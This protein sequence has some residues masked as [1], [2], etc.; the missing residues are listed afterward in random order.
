MSP[1]PH[2]YN[3]VALPE[4]PTSFAWK[5]ISPYQADEEFLAGVNTALPVASDTPYDTPL[6]VALPL[7]SNTPYDTPLVASPHLSP[8]ETL[9]PPLVTAL[10]SVAPISFTLDFDDEDYLHS[11]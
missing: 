4:D 11:S 3:N 8:I 9:P 7:A 5:P 10:P 2:R 6:V 1:C